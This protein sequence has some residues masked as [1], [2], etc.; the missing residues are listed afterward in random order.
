MWS[1]MVRPTLFALVL[2]AA[3]GGQSIPGAAQSAAPSSDQIIEALQPRRTRGLSV[4]PTPADAERAQVIADLK[5]RA[6]TRALSVGERTQLAEAVKDKPAIDIEIFFALDSAAISPKSRD[7]LGA[8]GTALRSDALKGASLLI[9]GHTD[10]HGKADY[11]QRLSERRAQAVKDYLAATFKVAPT[12]LTV[13]GY[14]SERL[15]VAQSPYAGENR[16]VQIVNLTDSRVSQK[17]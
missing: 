7:A 5:A 4:K 3:A 13:V 1:Q 16:R 14:G 15:K 10:A 12:A 2:A 8:L 11:N 6:A 9:A 17:P